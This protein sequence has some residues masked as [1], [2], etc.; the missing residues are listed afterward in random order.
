MTDVDTSAADVL[1][2][3][4]DDLA[5]EGIELAFAEMKSPVIDQLERYGLLDL[6]GRDSLLPDDRHRRQGVRRRHRRRVGRL[7]G[8]PEPDG[9]GGVTAPVDPRRAS[10][11]PS[12]HRVSGAAASPSRPRRG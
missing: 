10:C 5:A 6:L 9:A 3:L 1:E 7:G 8:R 12:D 11:Q 2:R 4:H